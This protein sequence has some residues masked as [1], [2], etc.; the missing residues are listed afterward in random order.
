MR[1][2]NA[3]K[4]QKHMQPQKHVSHLTMSP[5]TPSTRQLYCTPTVPPCVTFVLQCTALM[6]CPDVLPHTNRTCEPSNCWQDVS[7][8][9]R[10]AICWGASACAVGGMGL[11]STKLI[12]VE[13]AG[14][15]HVA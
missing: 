8:E 12:C 10:A 4:E 13:C 11:R 9:M 15:M 6:Y 5:C 2:T 7:R 1:S 3:S 14:R